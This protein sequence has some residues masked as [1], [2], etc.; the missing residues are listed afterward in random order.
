MI[1][2]GPIFEISEFS[3]GLY[4]AVVLTSW[5]R[6]MSDCECDIFY[7]CSI[8]Q[9]RSL[10]LIHTY[11]QIGDKTGRKY[12]EPFQRF[13]IAPGK[14][15]KRFRWYQGRPQHPAIKQGVNENSLAK[16]L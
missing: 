11:L 13:A 7:R 6:S 14:P 12:S 15:F 5:D 16:R 2:D 10:I 3:H 4:R 8:P 9:H 1:F